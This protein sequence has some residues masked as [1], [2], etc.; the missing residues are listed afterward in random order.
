MVRIGIIY[1]PFLL[2]NKDTKFK[3]KFLTSNVKKLLSFPLLLLTSFISVPFLLHNK[4]T[5]FKS[6]FLMFFSLF[7]KVINN[8]I[9]IFYWNNLFKVLVNGIKLATLIFCDALPYIFL[10]DSIPYSEP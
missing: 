1:P 2:H 9:L 8:F 6:E 3:L 4:D 5:Q 10:N 7:S